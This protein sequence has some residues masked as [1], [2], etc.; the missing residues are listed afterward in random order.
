[1][2]LRQRDSSRVGRGFCVGGAKKLRE[3]SDGEVQASLIQR[4]INDARQRG[5][6]LRLFRRDGQNLLERDGR[7]CE[8]RGLPEEIRLEQEALSERL[9]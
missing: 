7:R 8:E 1:M 3:P 4:E 6:T 2:Y 9:G 5:P